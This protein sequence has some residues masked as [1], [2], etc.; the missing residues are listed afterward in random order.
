MESRSERRLRA[1]QG[2][3]P[4]PAPRAPRPQRQEQPPVVRREAPQPGPYDAQPAYRPEQRHQP[5]P[6]LAPERVGGIILGPIIRY[7]DK[8]EA[9]GEAQSQARIA[10][11][12]Q[13]LETAQKYGDA[14]RERIQQQR[15][16]EQAVEAEAQQRL[17]ALQRVDSLIEGDRVQ[18]ALMNHQRAL[19]ARTDGLPAPQPLTL[20][21]VVGIMPD[22]YPGILSGAEQRQAETAQPQ[23]EAG[24]EPSP[25]QVWDTYE[26]SQ[27]PIENGV[28]NTAEPTDSQAPRPGRH[29]AV[30]DDPTIEFEPVA[31]PNMNTAPLPIQ[32]RPVD[33]PP[34]GIP[35]WMKR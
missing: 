9:I 14:A 8:V 19:Q 25:P 16:A 34:M 30:Y 33:E 26:A 2:A 24:Y 15:A 13:D 11:A 20:E 17:R 35:S 5:N 12:R 23:P 29:R 28:W 32:S 27:P 31:N 10:R 7:G 6:P 22:Y 1:Q 18:V 21:D 4:A 3:A